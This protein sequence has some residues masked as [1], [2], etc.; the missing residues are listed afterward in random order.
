MEDGVVLSGDHIKLDRDKIKKIN[1]NN[2]EKINDSEYDNLYRSKCS[3]ILLKTPYYPYK[4]DIMNTSYKYIPKVGDLVIG[5]VKSKKLDYYQMDINCN[6]ECII[7]KIE[8]F[9]Y[10]TKSSFPNLTN[11]TLL[12]MI[13]EKINLDNNSVI[14]SCINSSDVK[15]WINYEN[16]LGELVDGFLFTVNISYSKSLI[17]DKC[18]ILDLIGKDIKYEV[19][20]GHNG[21]VWIKTDDPL[22]TNM[23]CSALKHSFGKT[24][25]QMNVLWKSI[26]NLYKKDT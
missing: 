6:C 15:S 8:S 23:I 7:H 18:Y 13:V 16:Y 26:Y 3:G 19:A 11:G 2:F 4:Y 12:Y 21:W 25:A 24:K 10:A 5:I 17:G 20:I 9:K 14:T 22:E 1:E